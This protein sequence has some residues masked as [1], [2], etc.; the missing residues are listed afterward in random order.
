M[1]KFLN[2]NLLLTLIFFGFFRFIDASLIYK[3]ILFIIVTI[4]LI[5]LPQKPINKKSIFI[6]LG[7]IIAFIFLNEKKNIEEISAPLKINLLNEEQY[8]KILGPKKYFFIKDHYINQ[9]PNC[10]KN[11]LHC[12]LDEEIEKIYISPDQ[13]IFDIDSSLSRRVSQINFTNLANAR[14]PF[15]NSS[16][17]NINRHNIYKL[18]TPFYVEYKNLENLNSICFKG[19]V[20]IETMEGESFGK[21]QKEYTCYNQPFKSITGFN[22]PDKNLQISSIK[23]K[24]I[25]YLDDL[26]LLLFLIFITFNIDKNISL[27]NNLKLFL[28]VLISTF[29]VFYISRFDNWFQVFDL[30]NFYFFGFEGGDGTT[31]INFTNVLFKSLLSF[32]FAELIRAGENTFYFT[33]GLRFFLLLNQLISGDFYYFYFYV[34]FFVPKIVNKYL[35]HQFGDKAGYILTLSFLLLPVLHHLGFSYYQFLRHSYRLFPEP[36]GYMFFIAGLTLFFSNFKKNYLKMNLLFAISVFLRPNLILS[37]VMIVL[38]KTFRKKIK[39]F[40][41][42]NFFP[43]LGISLIYFFPL[44]HNLYFGDSFTLFTEYGSKMLSYENISS[45]NL[46]FYLDKI[47]SINFVFLLFILVPSLNI[48]LKIILIT[49]YFTAFWFDDNSRYYW[50]YWLVSLNLVYNT[51]KILY[52]NKWKFPKKSI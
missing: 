23:E 47:F 20:F 50:I 2:P 9:L 35:V 26:I 43:L 3:G 48:Y 15:I 52:L 18:D 19:L 46:Q 7:I 24:N 12:F 36:L 11:T 22:L 41:F 16:S 40:D 28:P 29:I 32:N 6:I 4:T 1:S 39:V 5:Y 44:V 21:N 37:V 34:L 31:Y 10:Y 25:Q 14:M 27:R 8:K 17:G 42:R 33:P 13:L 38:I 45:K 51:F 49:Q 30:Y